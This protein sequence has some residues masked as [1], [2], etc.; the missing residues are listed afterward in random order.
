MIDDIPPAAPAASA[1]LGLTILSLTPDLTGTPLAFLGMPGCS[2]YVGS[3]D[4]ALAFA[5][6]TPQLTTQFQIPAGV[7]YGT[8]IFATAVALFVPNSLPNGQ[9]AFGAVTSNGVAS[10]IS[11]F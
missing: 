9:N 8:Q 6:S 4:L 2:L 5:G 10:F 3:I 7:P 1:Y 11:T